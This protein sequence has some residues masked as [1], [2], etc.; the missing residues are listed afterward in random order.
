MHYP[1]WGDN[2]DAGVPIEYLKSHRVQQAFG[3]SMQRRCM[4]AALGQREGRR[5]GE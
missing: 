3:E 4:Y 1:A 5:A 2:G